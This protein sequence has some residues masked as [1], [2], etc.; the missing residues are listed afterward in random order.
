MTA[1]TRRATNFSSSFD[2]TDKLLIGLYDLVSV[3]SRP[4]FFTIGVM[5]AALYNAGNWP[6]DMERLY[7]SVRNGA[8]VVDTCH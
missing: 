6:V 3:G 2:T 8:T 1:T 7:S 4:A 5:E